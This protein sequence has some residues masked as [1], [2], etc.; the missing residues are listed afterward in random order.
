MNW[1][2]IFCAWLILLLSC[3]LGGAIMGRDFNPF[4]WYKAIRCTV[5]VVFLSA[6]VVGAL[7]TIVAGRE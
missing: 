7:F 3:Y 2:S 4:V 6:G 1:K 5:G